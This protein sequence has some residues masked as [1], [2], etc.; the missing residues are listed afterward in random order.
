MISELSYLGVPVWI[1]IIVV[2]VFLVAEILKALQNI[3]GFFIQKFFGIKTM[4]M[5]HREIGE[6][7]IKNQEEIKE[8]IRTQ[9]KIKE[10]S[11]EEDE[12]IESKVNDLGNKLDEVADLVFR[13]QI[14]NMRAEILD[15]AS[16]AGSNKRVYS[17]EHYS[18][19][20]KLY[21]EYENLL[22]KHNLTNGL[23]NES[24]EIIHKSYR[25]NVEKGNFLEDIYEREMI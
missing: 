5:K 14:N 20:F 16:G 15:F 3:L 13:M 9:D 23:V 10:K 8:L 25:K 21:S 4:A 6:I 18:Q 22:K 17:R 12:R 24:M 2:T 7:T 19:I 11:M 1:G